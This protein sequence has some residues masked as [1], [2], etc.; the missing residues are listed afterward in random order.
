[1]GTVTTQSSAP[2]WLDLDSG[3]APTGGA[4]GG[5]R[6]L[7]SRVKA[8]VK[9]KPMLAVVLR[10][11]SMVLFL[12]AAQGVAAADERPAAA[13]DISVFADSR[14]PDQAIISTRS[15]AGASV[16]RYCSRERGAPTVASVVTPPPADAHRLS[17]ASLARVGRA[18]LP[19]CITPRPPPLRSAL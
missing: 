3:D 2:G 16:L 5:R 15:P 17:S 12:A 6:R 13:R 1:M 11:L 14:G 4:I 19:F 18:H 8:G 7:R 9:M 10:A